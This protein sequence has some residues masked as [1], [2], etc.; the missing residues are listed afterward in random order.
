MSKT[1][2][3]VRQVPYSSTVGGGLMLLNEKGACVAQLAIMGVDK[4]RSDAISNELMTRLLA[5]SDS[6]A[7][8]DVLTERARQQ[9]DKGWTP[10]HDDEHDMYELA[11]AAA[12]YALMAAGYSNG[13]EIIQQLWPFP[14][15]W[16][17]PH[18]TR[19][20]DLVTGAALMLADIERLDRADA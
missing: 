9:V 20:G 17:K 18:P 4:E 19:R 16:P 12:C 2:N 5:T 13:H 1:F 8:K 11:R 7:A 14:D 3:A 10:E 15:G 6:Q